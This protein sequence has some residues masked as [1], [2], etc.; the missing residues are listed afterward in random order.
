MHS[1]RPGAQHPQPGAVEVAVRLALPGVHVVEVAGDV[2]AVGV[3]PVRE[4]VREAVAAGA[5]AVVL[6]LARVLLLASAGLT[7]LLET[8]EDLRGRGCALLVAGSART[9]RRP[10][11]ITGLDRVLAL[12]D[13]LVAALAAAG[14]DGTG[15]GPRG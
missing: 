12:H 14:A 5:R 6:D 10:L 4:G 1:D 7:L 3:G 2:D 11:A 8:T 15:P 9:V 13:D